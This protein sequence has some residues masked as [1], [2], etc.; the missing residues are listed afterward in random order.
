MGL[1][2]ILPINLLV[3]FLRIQRIKVNLLVLSPSI[4]LSVTRTSDIVVLQQGKHTWMRVGTY[5]RIHGVLGASVY[6]QLDNSSDRIQTKPV[7]SQFVVGVVLDAVWSFCICDSSIYIKPF[8]LQLQVGLVKILLY[9]S[10]RY[11]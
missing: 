2:Y 4:D 10:I 9:K 5:Q 7:G 3:T 11:L 8:I 6:H 1:S